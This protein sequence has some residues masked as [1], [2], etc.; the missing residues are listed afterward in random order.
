MKKNKRHK[1]KNQSRSSAS[2]LA[3]DYEQQYIDLI[4]DG[5][6]AYLYEGDEPDIPG[7]LDCFAPD[8]LSDKENHWA[9]IHLANALT[10]EGQHETALDLII[11]ARLVS[12]RCPEARC[13][14]A[15]I[16]SAQGQI[17]EAIQAWTALLQIPLRNLAYHS[18]RICN[19]NMTRARQLVSNCKYG[20]SL[21]YWE[22]GYPALGRYFKHSVVA[23]MKKGIESDY[24]PKGLL[25]IE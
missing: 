21:V 22:A 10:E 6:Q 24:D 25:I 7:L 17:V 3:P 19:T 1:K 16:F 12:P 20:L 14:M 5:V 8:F 18:C 9:R 4:R 11:D 13:V 23:D 15:R 2:G